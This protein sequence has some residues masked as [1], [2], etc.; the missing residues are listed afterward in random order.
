LKAGCGLRGFRFSHTI[1]PVNPVLTGQ[2]SGDDFTNSSDRHQQQSFANGRY[3]GLLPNQGWQVIL[4]KSF[5]VFDEFLK[6]II[7]VN[8]SV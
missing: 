3:H 8:C 4:M 6:A 1:P 2:L 5:D 7:G